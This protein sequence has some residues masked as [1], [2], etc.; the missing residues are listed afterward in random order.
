[1]LANGPTL[2]LTILTCIAWPN[3]ISISARPHLRAGLLLF[4][5]LLLLLLWL[6]LA[7]S[8]VMR[9]SAPYLAQGKA[10]LDG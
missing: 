5:L 2:V 8:A 10:P 4:M 6:I 7:T 1:M 9:A 3:D